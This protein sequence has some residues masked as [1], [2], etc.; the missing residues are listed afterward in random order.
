[1]KQEGA[2]NDLLE[3]MREDDLLGPHVGQG[4]LDGR[5]HVGRAPEQV[6]EFLAEYLEPLLD[7]HDHRRGRF[8]P[9]VRV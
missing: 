4:D 2:A 8:E 5:L 9:R 6:D 1:M 7:A 3:R